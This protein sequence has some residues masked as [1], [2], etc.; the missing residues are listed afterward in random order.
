MKSFDGVRASAVVL[1]LLLLL[2][3]LAILLTVFIEIGNLVGLDFLLVRLPRAFL[4]DC[5]I[6][7]RLDLDRWRV[8]HVWNDVVLDITIRDRRSRGFRIS[9]LGFGRDVWWIGVGVRERIQVDVLRLQVAIAGVEIVLLL[10]VVLGQHLLLNTFRWRVSL[11]VDLMIVVHEICGSWRFYSRSVLLG[12][13]DG[14]IQRCLTPKSGN[15]P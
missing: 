9:Q 6:L 1:L 7:W 8:V 13:G 2:L 3:L 14:L 4:N 12:L 5:D 11:L 10:L 15:R